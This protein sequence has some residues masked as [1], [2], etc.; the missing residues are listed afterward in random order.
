MGVVTCEIWRYKKNYALVV[1]ILQKYSKQ[2]N[3]LYRIT[4]NKYL[5][6]HCI[7]IYIK[8]TVEVEIIMWELG[9]DG[10][11]SST[12][13]ENQTLERGEKQRWV[14]RV[15]PSIWKNFQKIHPPQQ[16]QK[17][18]HKRNLGGIATQKKPQKETWWKKY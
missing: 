9:M 13:T 8:A 11:E 18:L 2:K 16:Y 1:S 12:E 6:V 5:L 15:H 14:D 4:Y 7:Y 10:V 17:P 3:Q